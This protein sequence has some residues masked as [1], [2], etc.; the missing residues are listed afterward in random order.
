MKTQQMLNDANFLFFGTVMGLAASQG[1]FNQPITITCAVVMIGLFGYQK[2]FA[3][4]TH[5]LINQLKPQE[6]VQMKYQVPTSQEL[7]VK[8]LTKNPTFSENPQVRRIEQQIH[9]SNPRM[10]QKRVVMVANGQLAPD[11]ETLVKNNQVE[12]EVKSNV[13][14]FQAFKSRR[15]SKS[16][17]A[18]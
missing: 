14:D 6:G 13:V 5:E 15:N 4:P 12:S 9:N 2:Y 1:A 16:P 11:V 10:K 7:A 3:P 18:G 8:F 17:E